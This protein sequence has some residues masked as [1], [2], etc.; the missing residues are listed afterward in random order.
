M[1]T[2]LNKLPPTLPQTQELLSKA[3]DDK[4]H[5][6]Q[7]IDDFQSR[8]VSAYA[9]SDNDTPYLAGDYDF[10][11]R[12]KKAFQQDLREFNYQTQ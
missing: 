4:A 9:S 6:L 7:F 12:L 3:F 5:L 8:L 2:T 1:Q 10:L 11:Y